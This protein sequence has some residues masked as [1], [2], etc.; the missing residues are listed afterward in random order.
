MHWQSTKFS[1]GRCGRR[2]A[3]P[4][5]SHM[6]DAAC[7]WLVRLL[8]RLIRPQPRASTLQAPPFTPLIPINADLILFISVMAS[9]P[10][11]YAVVLFDDFQDLDV[12]GPLDVL[13][14]LSRNHPISLSI[15]SSTL[16]PVTTNKLPSAP[17]SQ[18]ILPTHTFDS[19]PED[20]EVL[21]VP[22]GSGSRDLDATQ[23]AVGYIR[24]AFPRLRYLLTVCTGSAICARAGVL[25]GK[26]ATTNKGA[27]FEWV[28]ERHL[29]TALAL[30]PV[31]R[32]IRLTPA[33]YAGQDPWDRG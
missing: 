11:K 14:M 20:V 28:S 17:I 6:H 22:G 7:K 32:G 9:P 13:N 12:F 3:M 30:M 2:R 15:L 8:Q 25:D 26:R 23:P 16:E 19:P 1:V 10:I 31:E 33:V 21:L 4:V 29:W 27:S 18:R 24:R 5:A